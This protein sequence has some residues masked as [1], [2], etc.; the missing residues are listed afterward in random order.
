MNPSPRKQ[1]F[2]TYL[3]SAY[4]ISVKCF[5]GIAAARVAP[6][7]VDG[8]AGVVGSGAGEEVGVVVQVGLAA[9]QGR[10]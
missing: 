2:E 10:D 6:A 3:P 1:Q 5:E 7:A 4:G 9:S 8:I